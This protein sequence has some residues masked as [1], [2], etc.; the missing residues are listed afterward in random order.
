MFHIKTKPWSTFCFDQK[1]SNSYAF[2][3]STE[4]TYKRKNI[5]FHTAEKWMPPWF[6]Q[7]FYLCCVQQSST[8][9]S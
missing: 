5:L 9:S 8:V 6:A 1:T 4:P 7:C 3:W 2:Q